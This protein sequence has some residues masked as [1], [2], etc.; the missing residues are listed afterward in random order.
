MTGRSVGAHFARTQ[1]GLAVLLAAELENLGY[2]AP[3][4]AEWAVVLSEGVA[5]RGAGAL[6]AKAVAWGQTYGGTVCPPEGCGE[7]PT[8]L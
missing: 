5:S 8:A 4:A 1:D 6:A 7:Q 3:D 2:S